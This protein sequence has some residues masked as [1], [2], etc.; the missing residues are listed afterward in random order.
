MSPFV[1]LLFLIKWPRVIWNNV[2]SF[3]NVRST[4]TWDFCWGQYIS[5]HFCFKIHKG[6][7]NY[8]SLTVSLWNIFSLFRSF[9]HK[10]STPENCQSGLYD[11]TGSIWRKR[12]Y[13]INN[14]SSLRAFSRNFDYFSRYTRISFLRGCEK[15][16]EIKTKIHDNTIYKKTYLCY[17]CATMRLLLGIISFWTK[18]LLFDAPVCDINV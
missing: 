10:A 6:N 16:F 13:I 9:K 3:A 18:T 2:K 12:H 7:P 15:I 1:N 4:G 17:Q 5:F 8:E 14:I 11:E